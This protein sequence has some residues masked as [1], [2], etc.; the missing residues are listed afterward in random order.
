MAGLSDLPELPDMPAKSSGAADSGALDLPSMPPKSSASTTNIALPDM[1]TKGGATNATALPDMP[2]KATSVVGVG[3]RARGLDAPASRSPAW[4]RM[5]EIYSDTVRSAREQT[6]EGVDELR[7]AEGWKGY[8]TGALDVISGSMGYVFAP[9]TAL[10]R[11]FVTKPL[12]ENVG[13]PEKYTLPAVDTLVSLGTGPV[14]DLAMGVTKAATSSATL[15]KAV[16]AADAFIRPTKQTAETRA[17]AQELRSTRGKLERTTDQWKGM[18]TEAAKDS[19]QGKSFRQLT[20]DEQWDL[21]NDAVEKRSVDPA[22]YN[23][24]SPGLRGFVDTLST[25]TNDAWSLIKSLPDRQAAVSQY[26]QNYFP[27]LFEGDASKF[28]L[29]QTSGNQGSGGFL[30]QRSQQMPTIR[31]AM[32]AGYKPRYRDPLDMVTAYVDNLATFATHARWRQY[33]EQNHWLEFHVPGQQPDGWYAVHGRGMNKSIQAGGKA[34][35]LQ[36]Y[37]PKHVA[38]LASNVFGVGTQGS[39]GELMDHMRQLSNF[40]TSMEFILSTFHAKTIL[41]ESII[42]KLAQGVRNVSEGNVVQGAKQIA[43]APL[44][45]VE[46]LIEGH[47]IGKEWLAG[48]QGGMADL[49][50]EAGGRAIG[51]DK[52]YM[53]G[54]GSNLYQMWKKG[55]WRNEMEDLMHEWRN[56]HTMPEY[57]KVAITQ[58]MEIAARTMESVTA[59]L[60]ETIIPQVKRGAFGVMMKDYM[61]SN[62]MAT[63][64]E[65]VKEAQTV[66]NSIDNRFG[67]V[68][69]DNKMVS[70]RTKE[71]LF[72]GMRAPGWRLG[73]FDE[74]AGGVS[75]L[76]KTVTE[77]LANHNIQPLSHRAAYVISLAGYTA[78]T[79]SLISYALTGDE[80]QFPDDYISF[81]TEEP[82]KRRMLPGYSRD[83][84]H[85]AHDPWDYMTSGTATV[86]QSLIGVA[87]NKDY[88]GKPITDSM[89]KYPWLD[90]AAY[91]LGNL[92]PIALG[93]SSDAP[94]TGNWFLDAVSGPAPWYTD[95][96]R[97]E[98]ADKGERRDER[99]ARRAKARKDAEED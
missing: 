64:D 40:N 41:N 47:R 76:S 48:T 49:L 43:S 22:T 53:Y 36:A 81:P 56:A 92:T 4:M 45:P 89:D 11:G 31:Q 5:G 25:I 29:G 3:G 63:H 21:I 80:P 59:P 38:E 52:A 78:L 20:R 82:G 87:E 90:R 95:E 8:A 42:N 2:A 24:L 33:L 60:F 93:D 46:Q 12:E 71:A 70:K 34:G 37:A 97:R 88:A 14:R 83:V 61:R 73:T 84:M 98:R 19:T 6:A 86:W 35:S 32:A 72:V 75:D 17:A 39:A 85:F 16:D 44:A 96:G 26:T 30:K 51:R 77:A 58:G 50:A 62:P 10:E 79:N 54:K 99:R 74:I 13:I 66:W 68:V 1:P 57:A 15:N 67:E 27:H 28:K 55:S 94:T 7:D 23:A 18:L 91:A 65:I 69:W 9:L